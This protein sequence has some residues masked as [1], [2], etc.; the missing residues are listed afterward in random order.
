MPPLESTLRRRLENTVVAARGVAEA[1]ARAALEALAVHHHEPYGHMKPEARA[2]RNHLRARARQLGDVQN[3]KG[4]LAIGHLVHECAYE[5]WHRMLFARFLAEN[6]L[7]IDPVSKVAVSLAECEDLAKEEGVHTWELAARFAQAMLPQIF[8]VDD[9]L[10]KV[11]LPIERRVALE[12]LLAELPPAV[13]TADDSLGWVYQFW[14]R[15]AKNAANEGVKSGTKIDADTLPAVTQLFTEH[16]MVLFLLHNTIG[17]WWSGKQMATWSADKAEALATEADCRAAV[18]LPWGTFDYLRFVKDGATGAE[19][20]WRPAAGTYSG[21]PKA[22]KDLKVLDP[23]CGSG[24]FLVA[25]LE[26][27]VRLRMAEERLSAADAVAAVLREN[28]FGLELDLRCTQIAAFNVAL[29]AWRLAGKH[30]ALPELH[31][32]CSGVGPNCTEEQWIKLAEAKLSAS[33]RSASPTAPLLPAI[34]REPLKN[35]LRNLHAQFSKAPELGSLIDPTALPGDLIA[36]DYETMLPF[37]ADVMAEE[38]KGD[39]ESFERAVAAQGMAKA[40]E[41]LAGDY[42]LVITNVPYLGRGSQSEALKAHAE[43]HHKKAKADLATTFLSRMLRWIERKNDA[44]TLAAVTP[45]NWLFLKRYQKFREE[46]LREQRWEVVARLGPG[47]FETIGGH[48]VNVALLCISGTSSEAHHH[49]ACLD[50]SRAGSPQAKAQVLHG[51]ALEAEVESAPSDGDGVDSDGDLEEDGV[52]EASDVGTPP[53]GAVRLL[54]QA[55][56]LKNP[57][58]RVLM[59]AMGALP[60]LNDY[61]IVSEGLHTGDY[62]RFGRKHWELEGIDNGWARQQGG[63]GDDD[64]TGGCEHILFW[65]SGDGDLIEFVKARLDSEVVSMWIKGEEVWGKAGV[66]VGTM[67]DLKHSVYTGALFTHGIV[68]IVPRQEAH[69][70]ALL[71]YIESPEFRQHVRMLDQK[72]CV[73]RGAFERVPFDLER[74]QAAAAKSVPAGVPEPA[75]DDPTQWLFHGHPAGRAPLTADPSAHAGTVLQVAVARLAGYKWPAELDLE[76]RLAPDARA[77]VQ[78]CKD[79]ERFADDDGVIPLVPMRGEPAAEGRVRD[80]LRAAFGS[81]WSG[82][83]ETALLAAAAAANGGKSPSPNVDDWLKN[84]FF[85]EHCGLF[86]N[87]PFVW[88]IWDGRKK[89]GFGVLVHYHRLAAPNG[90]GRRLLEKITH[91]YLGDWIARQRDEVKAEKTG[92]DGRLADALELQ[93]KLEA[94]LEGEPPYDIFVRWKPLHEQPIGWEPDVND[95]VRMNIRPF[96]EA[97]VLREKVNIK[98]KTDRGQ[99]PQKLRPQA[100]FPWFWDGATFVG[101]RVNDV[102]LTNEEKQQARDAKGVNA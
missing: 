48:V 95:G 72:V 78:R 5:H 82:A 14:Q 21:W 36:A 93:K 66:A 34:G 41:I 99:E 42:T 37:L 58:S 63:S 8:R 84:R 11:A 46:L 35:G 38:A 7:L 61:A 20:G 69:G 101:D 25:T 40:A 28:L 68:A 64:G 30:M 54:K 96:V 4:E 80:L 70:A 81:D 45:Q 79:L 73:A 94:I 90:A 24:H 22:A 75:S 83:K 23:C 47:A 31:I 55:D 1:G 74:W 91:G 67:S 59:V 10:L 97:G 92:A 77:W 62:P 27:L 19:G 57:E 52:E 44:G 9:P 87:R 49:I 53:D 76:M 50:A 26:L 29:A 60:P 88:H 18:A 12:T 71:A 89:D 100:D 3:A 43:L 13:F 6:H 86:H 16:Y 15:D 32:A 33:R 102:H 56:Q 65:E 2:L 85:A 17:A 39:S 98:W 51:R